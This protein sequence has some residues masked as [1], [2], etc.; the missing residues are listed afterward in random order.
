MQK[1]AVSHFYQKTEKQ[2]C[3]ESYENI[4]SETRLQ[5]H[6]NRN[7]QVEGVFGVLKNSYEFQ[8]FLFRRKTRIKLEILL[9]CMG[10]NINKL[11]EEIQKERLESYFFQS[12]KLLKKSKNK[13]IIKVRQKSGRSP[14]VLGILPDFLYV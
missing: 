11:Y 4:Q 9:S 6:R 3:Q 2:K 5:Y 8:R 12:K 7:I 14:F 13:S 10:Y 1:N